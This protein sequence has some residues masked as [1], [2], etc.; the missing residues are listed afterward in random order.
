MSAPL[1]NVSTEE[2]EKALEAALLAVSGR[3]VSVSVESLAFEQAA[4]RVDIKLSAWDKASMDDPL[5]S[6][7]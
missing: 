1:K 6:F 4:S 5:G 7:I 2:L 3:V